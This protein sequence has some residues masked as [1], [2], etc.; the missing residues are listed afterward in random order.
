MKC[1]LRRDL[2]RVAQDRRAA[3]RRGPQPDDLRRQR[4]EPVVAVA[5]SMV[6]ARRGWTCETKRP[7]SFHTTNG[8]TAVRAF[9]F[10]R[11]GG[12][13]RAAKNVSE[14]PLPTWFI[15]V[16]RRSRYSCS[17]VAMMLVDAGV[18]ELGAELPEQAFGRMPER[19]DRR[20]GNGVQR[21][22][23]PHEAVVD[24][25]RELAVEQQELDDAIGRDAAV[26]LAVHL[27]RA[28]RAQQGGPLDVVERA[29]RRRPRWAAGGSTSRR[30]CAR[31]CRRARACGRAGR[32]ASASPCV[33]VASVMPVN[34]WPA[35]LDRREELVRVASRL[36]A[37]RRRLHHQVELVE[38][39]PHLGRDDLAHGAGVL[40]GGAQAGEDRIRVLRVERQELD[41]VALRWPSP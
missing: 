34:R 32:S 25:A 31:S 21:L 13:P 26:P 39:L 6:R 22:A 37:C 10:L 4:D 2:Q 9:A 19:P 17:P 36:A 8:A 11:A 15:L 16:C 5:G 18:G 30:G 1:S 28:G 35:M 3:V 38:L 41:D 29:C 23:R 33:I 27:E 40:A 14:I 7:V 20:A 24:G 12:A